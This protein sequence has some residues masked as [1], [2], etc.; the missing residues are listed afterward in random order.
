MFSIIIPVYNEER[1]ISK[2]IDMV[3]SVKLPCDQSL[4]VIVVNDGS[5][6]QT[7]MILDALNDQRLLI[8]HNSANSG[9]TAAIKEGLRHVRGDLVLV[10][11]ADLEYSP[12]QYAILLDAITQEGVDI[13]YGSRFLGNIQNMALI[14][15]WANVFSNIIFNLKFRTQLTDINTCFKLFPRSLIQ[16]ITIESDHFGFET[17][18][19]A[20][21]VKMNKMI[22]EVPINYMARTREEGKKIRW[23]SAIKMFWGIVKY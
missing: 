8:I 4:Q 21:M 10:Q 5:T 20:K 23:W 12:D 16:S 7:Q 11:D 2:L 17:E 3:L 18:V 13:V 19:T 6:D 9:K 1:T 14:N 22:K 15:R